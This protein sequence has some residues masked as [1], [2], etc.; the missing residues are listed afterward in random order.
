VE[1][2]QAPLNTEVLYPHWMP[3]ESQVQYVRCVGSSFVAW[4]GVTHL[5]FF[6]GLSAIR[7][8]TFR[9]ARR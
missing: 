2:L 1:A 5:M 4:S 3:R 8:S 7:Q 9:C 6:A